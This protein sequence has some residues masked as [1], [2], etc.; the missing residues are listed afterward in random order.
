MEIL[1]F[2]D[3]GDTASV[4]TNAVILVLGE[5]HNFNTNGRLGDIY[6]PIKL[7]CNVLGIDNVMPS[8]RERTL[9]HRHTDSLNTIVSQALRGSTN[10]SQYDIMCICIDT[11]W[12]A[13]SIHLHSLTETLYDIYVVVRCLTI[14]EY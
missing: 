2:K 11:T 13:L 3:L 6:P 14:D 5:C 8:H 7:Y 1:H 10:N 12:L 9:A 4:V